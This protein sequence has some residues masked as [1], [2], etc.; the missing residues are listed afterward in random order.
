VFLDHLADGGHVICLLP[1][2]PGQFGRM[3]ASAKKLLDGDASVNTFGT[4]VN[5][6]KVNLPLT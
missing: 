1:V 3:S 6:N 5:I 2:L 4:F